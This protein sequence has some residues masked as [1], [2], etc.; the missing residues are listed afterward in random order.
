MI[1]PTFSVHR[2]KSTCLSLRAVYTDD[3]LVRHIE[4]EAARPGVEYR[5]LHKTRRLGNRCDRLLP[6]A[7]AVWEKKGGV[8][9]AEMQKISG[10]AETNDCLCTM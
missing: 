6:M 1:T 10:F 5:D 9:Y 3:V 2:H 4:V 7:Y 8:P